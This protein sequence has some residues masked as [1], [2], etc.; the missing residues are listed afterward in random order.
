[1]V[2]TVVHGACLHVAVMTVMHDFTSRRLHPLTLHVRLFQLIQ[3]TNFPNRFFNRQSTSWIMLHLGWDQR[4]SFAK[5]QNGKAGNSTSNSTFRSST[6]GCCSKVRALVH[7]QL[8]TCHGWAIPQM[9]N[10]DQRQWPINIQSQ[11]SVIGDFLEAGQSSPKSPGRPFPPLHF[12][13]NYS[14][15]MSHERQ[16]SDPDKTKGK[17][18]QQTYNR[19]PKQLRPEPLRPYQTCVSCI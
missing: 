8:I 4:Y 2:V 13:R 6:K 7:S 17:T 14:R 3:E 12:Q 9:V 16:I 11:H 1:M 19:F 15:G 5:W 18:R 10:D